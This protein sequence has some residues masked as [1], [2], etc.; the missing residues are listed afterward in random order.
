MEVVGGMVE[1]VE[2]FE[3]VVEVDVGVVLEDFVVEDVVVVV[4]EIGLVVG[5]GDFEEVVVVIVVCV[6]LVY[7]DLEVF[8]VFVEEI[9]VVGFIDVVV[10]GDDDL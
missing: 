5:F 2:E 8:G 10:D 4:E 1:L 6:E 7:C 3:E 9:E